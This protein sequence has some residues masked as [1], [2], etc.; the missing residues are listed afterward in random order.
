MKKKKRFIQ[1]RDTNN[2]I[3][4][5]ATKFEELIFEAIQNKKIEFDERDDVNVYLHSDCH[6]V[7]IQAERRKYD[8]EHKKDFI[9]K[10]KLCNFY[11][12]SESGRRA[13]YT[14][15]QNLMIQHV[16]S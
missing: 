5:D 14:Y 11:S 7:Y 6:G 15:L 8:K 12:S 4:V 2:L 1:F 13:F 3:K 9:G 10:F 16:N